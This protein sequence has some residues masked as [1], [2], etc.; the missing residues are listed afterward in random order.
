M[1]FDSQGSDSGKIEGL[2]TIHFDFDKAG[3]NSQ[4]KDN[5]SKDAVWLKKHPRSKVQIEGHCDSRGSIEYNLALGERRAKAAKSYLN[6]LG[7]PNDQ[8][9]T[10]SYGKEKPLV[11]GDDEESMSKNR[12]ANLVIL[13]K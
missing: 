2:Y 4:A 1:S 7:V 10:I 11:N 6:D 9:T 5:L 3:L 8:L 12:R 13:E